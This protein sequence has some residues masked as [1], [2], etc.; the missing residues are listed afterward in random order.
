MFAAAADDLEP[1]ILSGN[2]EHLPTTRARDSEVALDAEVVATAL[3]GHPQ[4]EISG[5][6]PQFLLTGGARDSNVF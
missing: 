6:D 5:P 4:A 3:A 1:Q 2:P